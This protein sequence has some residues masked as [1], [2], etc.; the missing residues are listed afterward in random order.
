MSIRVVVIVGAL[1]LLVWSP[2]SSRVRADSGPPASAPVPVLEKTIR[3]GTEDR[4]RRVSRER[5]Q[6]ASRGLVD[7]GRV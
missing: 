7:S 4:E 3:D 2:L 1:T 5:I 6:T